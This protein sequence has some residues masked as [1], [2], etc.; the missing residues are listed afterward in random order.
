MGCHSLLQGTYPTRDWT[1]ISCIS[2]Q[3]LY[4]WATREA[5]RMFSLPTNIWRIKGKQTFRVIARL[6]P[7]THPSKVNVVVSLPGH[8]FNGWVMAEKALHLPFFSALGDRSASP[9][10][11]DAWWCLQNGS[12]SSVRK[13]PGHHG[14]GCDSTQLRTTGLLPRQWLQWG[15]GNP[16]RADIYAYQVSERLSF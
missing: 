7:D 12:E 6:K 4:H 15:C 14:T 5:L 1:H 2:R 8:L 9:P 13:A 16:A 3:I 10:L 11:P